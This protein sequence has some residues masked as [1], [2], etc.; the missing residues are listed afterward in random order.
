[1]SCTISAQ[2]VPCTS[3]NASRRSSTKSVAAA[4]ARQLRS[5]EV[6]RPGEA[7]VED[8]DRHAGA[9]GTRARCELAGVCRRD[10]LADDLLAARL[11]GRA[12]ARDARASPRPRAALPPAAA[13][14]AGGRSRP[15]RVR[16]PP[17]PA[18]GRGRRPH[19]AR[20][21]SPRSRGPRRRGPAS[22]TPGTRGAPGG[23]RPHAHLVGQPALPVLHERIARGTG[24]GRRGDEC[25]NGR[26]RYGSTCYLLGKRR[27]RRP[28]LN[29]TRGYGRNSPHVG[30]DGA[31]SRGKRSAK[32]TEEAGPK[33]G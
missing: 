19:P 1:M 18:R 16:P 13:P 22:G 11:E 12:D 21:R 3:S 8:R 28:L 5:D 23:E 29:Q 14:S 4:S 25:E 6:G 10:A 7:R 31:R 30:G 15:A 27:R 26:K 33:T 20:A 2:A 17:R 32:V 9:G 24:R